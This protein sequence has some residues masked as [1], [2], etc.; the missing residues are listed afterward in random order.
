MADVS[1]QSDHFKKKKKKKKKKK[2]LMGGRGRQK[3]LFIAI[4][5][6]HHSANLVMPDIDPQDGFF[7]L[8]L[9]PM[10]DLYILPYCVH[11]HE[12]DETPGKEISSVSAKFT[13]VL[14]LNTEL[15]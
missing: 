2:S 15:F 13:L 9:P 4:I 5:V 8:P 3:N 10:I 7:Y 1:N 6:W 14:S 11:C 12:N